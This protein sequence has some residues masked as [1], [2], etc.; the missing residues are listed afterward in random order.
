MSAA[1]LVWRD[2]RKALLQEISQT[3]F[4]E[5]KCTVHC[6]HIADASPNR[7]AMNLPGK[8]W[9]VNAY[10]I[11]VEVSLVNTRNAPCS[12]QTFKLIVTKKSGEHVA[13]LEPVVPVEK[14]FILMSPSSPDDIFVTDALTWENALYLMDVVQGRR[15]E[16]G[17]YEKAWLGFELYQTTAHSNDLNFALDLIDGY[18]NLHH[19][20]LESMVVT[21][22]NYDVAPKL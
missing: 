22:S 10:R 9:T 8:V 21:E 20:S 15:M 16:Q 13:T 1:Y 5:F 2:Q 11:V 7:R 19:A 3:S 14:N 6:L 17:A 18:D 12:V 4:P